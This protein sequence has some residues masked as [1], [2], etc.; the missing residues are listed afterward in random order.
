MSMTSAQITE[1]QILI[2]NGLQSLG[3][4][5]SLAM[6]PDAIKML[7]AQAG[8]DGS[9]DQLGTWLSWIKT[10]P[11]AM[12]FLTTP[13]ISEV[14]FQKV[15]DGSITFTTAADGLPATYIALHNENTTNESALAGLL[16][17]RAL[18]V[19]STYKDDGA[20]LG[21]GTS[22]N[23]LSDA[24]VMGL[25]ST[26]GANKFNAVI[27]TN[28]LKA[29][30]NDTNAN[31]NSVAGISALYSS[32]SHTAVTATNFFNGLN[33][34]V[35]AGVTGLKV[36]DLLILADNAANF[37]LYT[38]DPVVTLMASSG[39]SFSAI[40]A[41]STAEL[42]EHTSPAATT[43]IKSCGANYTLLHGV[44]AADTTKYSS[45]LSQD[46]LNLAKLGLPG[47]NYSALSTFYGTTYTPAKDSKY[48]LV[49]GS[50]NIPLI[51]NGVT[52]AHLGSAYDAGKLNNFAAS[53]VQKII[54]GD[55]LHADNAVNDLVAMTTSSDYGGLQN[56]GG[57]Y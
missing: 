5:L 23:V 19:D 40:T 34:L 25:Y 14:N 32:W 11:L 47:I 52:L 53:D 7:F 18:G 26:W 44:Y 12:K 22:G 1:C 30:Y 36:S 51:K 10:K 16:A 15:I 3:Q 33:K 49:V 8:G 38:S 57:F 2:S 39:G 42:A 21:A 45:L 55:S 41:L 6:K 43:A 13:S 20:N 54:S 31:Y 50:A 35:G 37:T 27:N 24:Y 17:L 46:S 9:T 48:N 28:V 4:K 29:V 56:L